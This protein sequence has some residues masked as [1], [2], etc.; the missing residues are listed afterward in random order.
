MAAGTYTPG[1]TSSATYTLRNNVDII[2]GQ[3]GSGPTILSGVITGGNINTIVTANGTTAILDN[4]TVSGAVTPGQGGGL[5]ATNGCNI[6]LLNDSF[7]ND[8]STINV[9]HTWRRCCLFQQFDFGCA[10]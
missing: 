8:S 3:H 1:S 5:S 6:L 4:L 7:T 2:G 9:N 10:K